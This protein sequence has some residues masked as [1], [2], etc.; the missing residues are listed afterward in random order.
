MVQTLTKQPGPYQWALPD[1]LDVPPDELRARLDLYHSSAVLYM[2]E[3][4]VINTRMVSPREIS[5][6][7]LRNVPLS[8]GILPEGAVW[9][10]QSKEGVAVA[11]WR[12]PQVWRAALLVKEL[13]PP[14]RFNLPMP[15]LIF[16]CWPGRPPMVFAAMKRP[17]GPETELFHAPLF[18]VYGD[19]R[20]CPGTHRYPDNVGEIPE[21]FF[22]AFFSMA[23]AYEKRSKR[24][25]SSLIKLWEEIDGKKR[26]PL[27]DLVRAG[28]VGDLL[29]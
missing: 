1:S 16:I 9:W 17:K 25:P 14:R 15:G 28:K 18:N 8:S 29:K 10:G 26:Y 3:D 24:H 22:M 23:A 27:G 7:L 5:L 13:E 20:T 12:P 21:S 6:A 4:G 2:V 19:G 11:L